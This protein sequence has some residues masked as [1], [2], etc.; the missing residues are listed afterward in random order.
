[1]SD[2]KIRKLVLAALFTALC[3]IMTLVIQVPSLC[4]AMST[5]VTAPCCSPL[6][7]WVLSTAESPQ[8]SA[9]CWPTC[10]RDMPITP[11]AHS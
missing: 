5:W 7:S 9:L 2:V 11:R 10:C 1:M 8:A 4:K 3:T 6:G